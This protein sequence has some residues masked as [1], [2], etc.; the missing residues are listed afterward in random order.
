MPAPFLVV[1][2]A[3]T[4]LVVVTAALCREVLVLRARQRDLDCYLRWLLQHATGP[5]NVSRRLRPY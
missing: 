2:L 1:L 3:V 5:V 4:T